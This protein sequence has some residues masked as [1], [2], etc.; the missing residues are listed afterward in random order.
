MT[1]QPDDPEFG[2]GG[3][4]AKLIVEGREVTY[5]IVINGNKGSSDRSVTPADLAR[6]R[7]QEHQNAAR[8]LGVAG[9]ESLGS[10]DGEVE[11]TRAMRLDVTRQ[12]R[13]WRPSNPQA[14]AQPTTRR[15]PWTGQGACVNVS[16]LAIAT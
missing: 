5:A 1:A 10:E 4:I 8:A 2:A 12:I 9:V 11:D 7:E 6:I 16:P 13:R 3:T 14:C 15:H